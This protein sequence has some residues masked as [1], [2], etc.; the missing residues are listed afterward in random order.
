MWGTFPKGSIVCLCS[1]ARLSCK[2]PGL[3][4]YAGEGKKHDWRGKPF[5]KLKRPPCGAIPG[6]GLPEISTEAELARNE[7]RGYETGE[8]LL[9]RILK[10]RRAKWEADHLAK[11]HASGKPPKNDDCKKKYKEPNHPIRAIYQAARRVG[12]GGLATACVHRWRNNQRSK[13]GCKGRYQ[14]DSVTPESPLP[15]LVRRLVCHSFPFGF[16]L[17]A[18][19]FRCTRF[20]ETVDPSPA[21]A[22]LPR[23]RAC[24]ESS[25]FRATL[26]QALGKVRQISLVAFPKRIA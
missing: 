15:Q 7:G 12:L 11:M 18:M 17:R 3:C 26:R 23:S 19:S 24:T 13:E 8:Q 9:A 21:A 25:L 22:T 1:P 4:R 14:R 6:S 20:P 16:G 2:R 5:G 10:E